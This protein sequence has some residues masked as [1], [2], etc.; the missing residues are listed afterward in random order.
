[1]ANLIRL[2]M[3]KTTGFS[4]TAWNKCHFTPALP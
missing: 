2:T 3:V 4:N 1:V